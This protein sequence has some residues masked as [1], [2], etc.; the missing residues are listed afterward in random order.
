MKHF[1]NTHLYVAGA[2]AYAALVLAAAIV[3]NNHSTAEARTT[4]QAVLTE[5]REK[6]F[7]LALETDNNNLGESEPIIISD[8]GRRSEFEDLLGRLG[9]LSQAEL[10]TTQQ[11]FASCGNYYAERKALLVSQL[12]REYDTFTALKRVAESLYETG[13]DHE[14]STWETLIEAERRRSALLTEQSSVQGEI[15]RL[16]LG[17]NVAYNKSIAE[18][19]QIAE[20]INTRLIKENET[21]DVA[22]ASLE[23]KHDRF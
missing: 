14:Q 9:S 4:I 3:Y 2:F 6:L 23:R 15:I 10:L 12:S 20:G 21:I 13:L 19:I 8:C 22:L 1:L 18:Q 7:A 16:L 11:L 17:G 5:Q